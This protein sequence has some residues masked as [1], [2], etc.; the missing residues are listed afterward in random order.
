M[1]RVIS[2]DRLPSR[3]LAGLGLGGCGTP[4]GAVLL[5]MAVGTGDRRWVIAAFIFTWVAVVAL[6]RSLHA[7]WWW[8]RDPDYLIAMPRWSGALAGWLGAI[9]SFLGGYSYGWLALS[10][11]V[12]WSATMW[13]D[14]SVIRRHQAD[15]EA[16]NLDYWFR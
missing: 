13:V 11:A 4:A 7:W 3:W 12:L 14:R 1:G 8:R 9:L 10:A 6:T 5:V 16:G 15:I 2:G